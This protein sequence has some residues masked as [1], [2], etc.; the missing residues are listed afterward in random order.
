LANLIRQTLF[1]TE[2]NRTLPILISFPMNQSTKITVLISTYNNRAYV[3]KKLAE[4]LRQSIFHEAEFIF[5]E[6]ASP[7]REREELAPF[8]KEYENCR[9][10]T[11]ENRLS[12]YEAWNLGWKSATAPIV[13]ISNMDDAMHPRLLELVVDAMQANHWD[14]G[15]ALIAKQNLDDPERDSWTTKRLKKLKLQER[16][17]SFFVWRRDL[18]KDFGGF[19]TK[20]VIAGDKDFWARADHRKLSMGVVPHILY[21]YTKHANQLSKSP[22]YQSLKDADKTHLA[23]KPYPHIWPKEITHT[24]RKIKRR[25]RIPFLGNKTRFIEL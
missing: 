12:L 11:T 7:E 1:Y 21:L 22:K 15:T 8:C 16:P 17:G 20:F 4:I 3:A 19:D 2:G 9:L 24:V 18:L 6:T 23:S 14:L 10:I 5:L 25:G 13:C